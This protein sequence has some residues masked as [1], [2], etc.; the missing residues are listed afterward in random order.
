MGKNSKEVTTASLRGEC[1]MQIPRLSSN[2]SARK[3][4]FTGVLT[5]NAVNS[6]VVSGKPV[7]VAQFEI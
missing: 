2:Q 7:S 1:Q 4:I 6:S 3:T 5:L